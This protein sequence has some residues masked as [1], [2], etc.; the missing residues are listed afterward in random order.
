MS[1]L[2]PRNTRPALIATRQQRAVIRQMEQTQAEAVLARAHD[3]AR[4]ELAKGLISDVT[5]V[6]NHAMH[7]ALVIEEHLKAVM[8]ASPFHSELQRGIAEDAGIGI[9]QVVRGFSQGR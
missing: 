3:E 7:E 5:D 1:S 9:R 2:V 4:R 8:D 6:A